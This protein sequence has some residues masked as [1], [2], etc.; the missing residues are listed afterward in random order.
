MQPRY[1]TVKAVAWERLRHDLDVCSTGQSRKAE[2]HYLEARRLRPNHLLT[3][4]N[5][6]AL[7]HREL[8]RYEEAEACY[9]AAITIDPQVLFCR[10]R[11]QHCNL[12]HL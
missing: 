1:G 10:P 3:H 5:L 11:P 2:Y 7:Y 4:F 9:V 6:G 12:T 8:L